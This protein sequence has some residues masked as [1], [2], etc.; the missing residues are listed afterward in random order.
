MEITTHAKRSMTFRQITVAE[1]TEALADRI[2]ER[3][4]D[5]G[6]L[7]VKGWTAERRQLRIVLAEDG[8]VVVSVTW[9]RKQDRRR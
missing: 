5:R 4:S 3:P 9:A 7:V 8:E 6:R 2:S 1:V